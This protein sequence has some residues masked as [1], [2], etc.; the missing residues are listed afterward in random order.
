[1][2]Y[3][4]LNTKNYPEI[5]GERFQRL[6]Q[7]FENL[8]EEEQYTDVLKFFLAAPAY[9]IAGTT[10]KYRKVSMLAQHLDDAEMG[11]TTGFLVPQMAHSFGATGSLV[12]HS[13]HRLPVNQIQNIV[14]KLRARQMIS[15]VCARDDSEV[16]HFS[17]FSPDFIAI[18]PPELIGSGIAVSKARPELISDSRRAL[19][20]SKPENSPT[21][22]ICGA[23]IVD[24]SDARLAVELGSEGIL[25]A[26]GVIKA[27]DWRAKI[28]ELAQGIISAKETP[29]C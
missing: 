20:R 21:R 10:Q 14:N 16:Q 7:V 28:S 23:G 29:R 8:S 19:E 11:A 6:A 12:N 17:A 22:L 4:I 26:S 9:A 27:A 5:S 15:I 18:E 1:M 3:F 24:G 13:E 2:R 25:V